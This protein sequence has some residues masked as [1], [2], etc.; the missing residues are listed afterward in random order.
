MATM[1]VM[2]NKVEVSTMTRGMRNLI[3]QG[4]LSAAIAMAFSPG[5]TATDWRLTPNVGA[6]ITLSDNVN[7]SST[8]PES[9]LILNVTPGFSL[10]SEGSR[11]IK[12]SLTYSLSAVTRIGEDTSSDLHHYLGGIGNAELVE[13][14]LFVDG[15][16]SISQELISLFGS[17]ADAA[18]NDANRVA[19]GTYSISP[20]LKKRLGTFAV[21]EA[22][23]TNSGSIFGQ[24]AAS[25]T[26]TNAFTTSLNSGTRFDDFSWGLNYSLRKAEYDGATPNSTFERATVSLGYA[27]SRKFRVFGTYGEE[28]NEFLSASNV[29]GSFYSVGAAWSPTRRTSLEG[30]IGERYFGR[31]Y[32]FSGR[33]QT[34]AS[35]WR[36][37]YSEDVS[38]ISQQLV[39]FSSRIFWV[40]DGRLFETQDFTPPQSTCAGPLNS[41]Q[42]AMGLNR[43]GVPVADLMAKGLFNLAVQNGIYI[44]K[45]LTADVSWTKGRLGLGFSVYDIRRLYQIAAD[46]EDRTQGVTGTIDYRLTPRTSAYTSLSLAQNSASAGLAGASAREDDVVTLSLGMSHRFGKDF[47][48]ALIF[49]HMQRDSNIVNSDYSENSLTAS[50]NLSF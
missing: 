12:A 5:A 10:R 44:L 14:F 16:A 46:A 9:A 3:P 27:L 21:A 37:R 48:G 11:R 28:S 20:Y 35:N 30:S 15:V 24:N 6:A 31:T 18:T 17:S 19:V 2:A 4:I 23:Y 41:A 29:D 8:D 39:V 7:Q 49:R 13:D 45:S 1:V 32:S 36:V 33:H 40:C 42:V 38:D 43:L 25:D 26:S 47:S 34:R 50:A 22:R